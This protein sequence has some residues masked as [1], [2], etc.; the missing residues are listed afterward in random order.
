MQQTI[1][2]RRQSVRGAAAQA[3]LTIEPHGRAA[4]R[5][6]GRKGIDLVVTDL[7]QVRPWELR[8]PKPGKPWQI[9][10]RPAEGAG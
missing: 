5:I 9:Q 3:G 10:G 1:E 4:W 7:A 6:H 8:P 2:Q